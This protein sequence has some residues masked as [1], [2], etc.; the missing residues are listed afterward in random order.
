MKNNAAVTVFDSIAEA[1]ARTAYWTEPAPQ[2]RMFVLQEHFVMSVFVWWSKL[3][4]AVPLKVKGSKYEPKTEET[5]PANHY[6]LSKTAG[7]K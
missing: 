2:Q 1:K 6:L 5:I 4:L 7:D 3:S